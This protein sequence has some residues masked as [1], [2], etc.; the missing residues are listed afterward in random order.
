MLK[1]VQ[2]M[3]K[4]AQAKLAEISGEDPDNMP[5]AEND[6]DVTLPKEDP[7][8]NDG[9]MGPE[10]TRSTEGKGDDRPITA[11]DLFESDESIVNPEE[12]P[13]ETADANAK[14]AS[15][16]KNLANDILSLI[17][18]E[19]SKPAE[20]KAEEKKPA[21]KKAEANKAT[22]KPAK[23]AEQK[24]EAATPELN[25][26][27]TTDVL[28]K[29]ACAMLAEKEGA[30]IAEKVMAKQA[31][32]DK[33][34]EIM[35]FVAGQEKAAEEYAAG[36]RAA[37]QYVIK[38][39]QDLGAAD[40]DA[41]IEA[42]A[43]ES[44]E[45]ASDEAAVEEVPAEPEAPAEGGDDEMLPEDAVAEVLMS[46]LQSGDLTE[47][48]L[49]EIVEELAAEE[50]EVAEELGLDLGVDDAGAATAEDTAAEPAAADAEP[51][52][53]AEPEA[54]P[55]E[56]EKAASVKKTAIQKKAE[57]ITKIAAASKLLVAHLGK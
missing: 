43:A 20:K 25:L 27:L 16:K 24:K 32:A 47:D 18:G 38:K 55:A 17:H 48:D 37:V 52:A 36:Q 51:A 26:E 1:E 54:E 46:Q 23:K 8:V 2:A 9:S 4:R 45:A 13:L 15:A 6:K 57:L 21:E 39:A 22:A 40:A 44:P 14:E 19:Q 3:T 53:A 30:E 33:A 34:R 7:E 42:M 49:A 29:L 5:G 56:D 10:S 31:G 11:G 28:A 12:K 50:P 35:D 41:A